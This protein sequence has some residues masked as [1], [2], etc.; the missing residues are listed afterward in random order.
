[1][2]SKLGT[3]VAG[4]MKQNAVFSEDVVE[5]KLSDLRSGDLI[6]CWDGDELFTCSVDD[7][8]D[9]SV[10]LRCQEL[11]NEVKGDQMPW[12]WRNW[13]LLD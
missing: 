8:E 7:V 11:F 6:I 10:S 13:E 9:C 5:E 12:A 3:T 1:M 2:Q 4:D